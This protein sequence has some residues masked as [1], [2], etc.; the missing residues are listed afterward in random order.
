MDG[1]SE[2]SLPW[3]TIASHKLHASENDTIVSIQAPISKQDNIS[4]WIF[5]SDMADEV[6]DL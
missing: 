5:F 1:Q 6:H 4:W 3:T 2:Q